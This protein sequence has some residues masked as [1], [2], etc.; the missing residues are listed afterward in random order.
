MK[1]S[2]ND[3]HIHIAFR[4]PNECIRHLRLKIWTPVGW[5]QLRNALCA[6]AIT[7]PWFPL[8]SYTRGSGGSLGCTLGGLCCGL[9]SKYGPCC[10]HPWKWPSTQVRPLLPYSVFPTLYQFYDE[11]IKWVLQFGWYPIYVK[12]QVDLIYTWAENWPYQ[13]SI[14]LMRSTEISC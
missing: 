10:V 5:V 4:S 9:N 7:P 12:P 14:C 8:P 3:T 11:W 6:E 1:S 2:S 13:S